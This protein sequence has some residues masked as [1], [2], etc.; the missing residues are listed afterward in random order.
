MIKSS[1]WLL[2]ILGAL[3]AFTSLS[4]DVYLP[5][6]PQMAAEL[7]G[8]VEL[9]V[10]GFLVGF[11]IAQLIWGAVSDRIGRKIPLYIGMVLFVIGSIGCAFSHSINE[12]VFWRIFQA[13]GACTAPL[14]ARAI[15]RDL[16]DKSRAVQMLSTLTM[17]MAVAPIIGPLLGGQI[18]QF[19]NWKMIFILLAMI[20]I[21]M[22][23]SLFA[24]PETLPKEQR[25]SG[26]FWTIFRNY[27]QLLQN[28]RFMRYTLCVTFFYVGAY[29][30]VVGSPQVYIEHFNVAPQHY[31][32]LFAL[33]IV[34]IMLFS[35]LNKTLSRR[36]ALEL[37]LKISTAIA[38][39]A[40][41][42]MSLMVY[43][44]ISGI[45]AVIIPI[46]LFFSM[47]GIIASCATASALDLVPTMAGSGAALI[48]SLQY[49]SG[50]IS[51]LLLVCFSDGTASAMAWIIGVF[52]LLSAATMLNI[53]EKNS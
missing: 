31:G 11:A 53:Y 28:H 37:L 46:F 42:L 24:L 22:F 52:A 26:R 1:P 33:N 45:Y 14:L 21:V 12:I 16:F 40:G 5:A 25:T 39:F 47:N 18:V 41:I 23:F 3:M 17:I 43:F 32:W 19:G 50:I 20:G 29:A 35:L 8:N 48:G 36:F 15:I 34:G 4:T 7:Q 49:G 10:T 44:N 13:F 51:S 30:F 27:R 38:A 6:M 9:T 2:V